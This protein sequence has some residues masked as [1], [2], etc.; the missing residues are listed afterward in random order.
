MGSNVTGVAGWRVWFKGGAKF[1]SASSAWSGLPTTGVLAVQVYFLP[2][3]TNRRYM[4]GD[5]LY[6][7]QEVAGGDA[8]YGS[9]GRDD[10]M[11]EAEVIAKYPGAVVLAGEWTTDAE[12]AAVSNDM[13]MA[14]PP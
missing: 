1:D 4:S 9:T 10:S 3:R 13:E 14:G 2:T 11:T 7:R 12:M 8:I 6:F 5:D